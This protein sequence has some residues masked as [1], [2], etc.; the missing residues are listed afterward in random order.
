MGWIVFCLGRDRPNTTTCKTIDDMVIHNSVMVAQINAAD[1][2]P[3]LDFLSSWH[4][5]QGSSVERYKNTTDLW[6]LY[7]LQSNNDNQDSKS[8]NINGLTSFIG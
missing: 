8:W 7:W 6:E 1:G 5:P 2:I 4:E 3:G